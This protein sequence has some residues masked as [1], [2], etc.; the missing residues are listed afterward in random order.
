MAVELGSQRGEMSDESRRPGMGSPHSA[1]AWSQG[2]SWGGAT[3]CSC[4]DRAAPVHS[5]AAF[6]PPPPRT[7]TES[8]GRRGSRPRRPRAHMTPDTA[9]SSRSRDRW[10]PSSVA[11]VYK[12]AGSWR[13]WVRQSCGKLERL[14]RVRYR[15][16]GEKGQDG[17]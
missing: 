6:P 7:E 11:S 5:G 3:L 4:I 2:R 1:R 16:T 17:G 10:D 8:P 12:P 13:T 15:S 14:A 9:A